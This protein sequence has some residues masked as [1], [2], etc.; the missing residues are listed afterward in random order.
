MLEKTKQFTRTD[1]KTIEQV[2]DQ[3]VV[4]INH[5]VLPKGDALPEHNANSNVFMTVV[6]G[7]VT[8]QLGSQEAH[9]YVHGNIIEI[10]FG[11]RMNVSNQHD[12]TL[13]LFVVKA[14]GPRI[15]QA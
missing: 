13:E 3:D 2:I 6:R 9:T 8:L 1:E 12:E 4:M 11:T 7:T 14:P 15:A 5:M 10:P